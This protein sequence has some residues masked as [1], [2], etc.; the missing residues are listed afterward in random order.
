[1]P[2]YSAEQ[3]YGFAIAAGFS[4]DQAT[5]MTA[6]ALAESGGN[7]NSHNTTP[8]EDSRGLWQINANA[9]PDLASQY[10][11]YD[12][13]DNAKAALLVSNNGTN[14][15]AWTTTH[16]GVAAKYLRFKDQA[17]A[18]ALAHGDGNDLGVWTG[19]AGYGHPLT[20]G[21]GRSAPLSTEGGDA[22]VVAHGAPGL[23]DSTQPGQ[24]EAYGIAFDDPNSQQGMEYGIAF[25]PTAADVPGVE[26]TGA[27]F[28]ITDTPVTNPVGTVPAA[29]TAE[30]APAVLV[31][32]NN[33][34]AGGGGGRNDAF[35]NA[36]LAQT[37]D[38][39]IF[40]AETKL[41][42]PDPH[43]FDCSELVQWAA[44]Q[45]GVDVQDGAIYQYRQMRDEGTLIPVEQA[46][47]T[48]GALLFSFGTDPNAP[49][50]PAHAHVAISLGDGRTIEARGHAYPVGS[51]AANTDRF[52]YAAYI[53]G[54]A[55]SGG[56]MPTSQDPVVV[57]FLDTDP[58][59]GAPADDDGWQLGVDPD[60]LDIG[61]DNP[62]DAPIM[63][64]FDAPPDPG[65]PAT[66]PA[67]ATNPGTGLGA[68]A[69]GTAPVGTGP[70]DPTGQG[71]APL[72]T[73]DLDGDGLDDSLQHVLDWSSAPPAGATTDHSGWD[74]HDGHDH[75]AT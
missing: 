52:N 43:A 68:A 45:A 47:H 5:T 21:T 15:S 24:G 40:G 12:P 34:A 25:D 49:G 27:D 59:T 1:M 31:G 57:P 71:D 32:F 10:N 3:I 65:I 62:V 63:V 38:T 74:H 30:G 4:P 18:A 7:G 26:L 61:P 33:P 37:G 50:E 6:I 56:P 64:A 16:H 20:A 75:V 2:R 13:V 8:P 66:G 11:L 48:K 67:F 55:A 39:Y 22:T 17:Q 51:Y 58:N 23:A 14:V 19:T 69:L 41:N 28:G 60:S 70:L 53:P 73:L 36:A 54:L 9:H 72:G 35:V 44:H 29:T 42:D 46:I